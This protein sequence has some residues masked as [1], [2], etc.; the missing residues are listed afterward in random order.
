MNATELRRAF[1][2]LVVQEEGLLYRYVR[3]LV[4]NRSDAEEVFQEA[5]LIAWRKFAEFEQG[6]NFRAWLLQIAFFA[7]CNYRR[8]RYRT[9]LE[10]SDAF[11][12]AIADERE[13]RADR[14]DERAWALDHCL[15]RLGPR[16]RELLRRRYEVGQTVQEIAVQTQRSVMA[17]YKALNRI[18]HSLLDCIQ[19]T[20]RQEGA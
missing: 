11:A 5:V 2:S 19:R 8:A 9:P 10:I 4:R 15:P 1:A 6:T 7:A 3:T 16:E 20:L 18:H 13:T 17:V 14:L 12:R